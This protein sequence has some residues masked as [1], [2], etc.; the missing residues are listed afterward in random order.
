M[1]EIGHGGKEI[2]ERILAPEEAAAR[3]RGLPRVPVRSQIAN[4]II[5]IAYG[6]FCPLEGFM[7]KEDVDAVCSRMRLKDG[8][9]WSI[10]ILFD[11]SKEELADHGIKKGDTLCLTYHD[12]PMAVMEV[13]EIYSYDKAAICQAVYGTTEEKHP[14][15]ARTYAYKDVF[16][17]GPV[18]LV[19]RPVINPPFDPYFIPPLEMRK[20]F[21]EKGWQRIVA[22]QTRN[23]PHTGHEWLMKGAWFQTYAELPIEK[24]LVGVLVNAIIGEKRKGDYIDEAIILTQD[25]L[26]KAGY[27]GDHNHM[28]S[29]TF[30]DMRYAGPREAVFHAILR[31]NLGLTHHMFGRD[32][33]GVGTYYG[34]YDAHRLLATVQDELAITPVYSMNWLYCPHC[35]EITSEGLC[36]HR[37]EWQKFSGTVIRSIVQDGVKPPRLIFRPEVFDLV[38]EC[39]EKYG[40]GSPFVTDEYLAKRTPVFTIPAL[41][42]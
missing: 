29:L 22:H 26:R 16:L 6:W 18:T 3:V 40:F 23:V 28:T 2:R 19:T 9:V 1:A 25:E 5:D 39:A 14:G 37:D 36:N 31:T 15:C 24:P 8:T 10:P 11:L 12:R 17:A 41:E 34:P 42:A 4:E 30:W 21:R 32:H 27:F 13:R 33:A 20:R 7:G 38:M 35:G